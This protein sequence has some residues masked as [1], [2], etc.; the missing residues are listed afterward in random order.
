MLRRIATLSG[1][2]NILK[3][4]ETVMSTCLNPSFDSVFAIQ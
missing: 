1:G 4:G 2:G 3:C